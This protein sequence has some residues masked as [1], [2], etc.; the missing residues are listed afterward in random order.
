MLK[1][2]AA[3]AFIFAG[4]SSAWLFLGNTVENRTR[5]SGADLTNRVASVWGGAH[6]QTPPRLL[7]GGTAPTSLPLASTQIRAQLNLEP[8]QKGLLWFN[9][10]TIDFQADYVFTTNNVT[11]LRYEFPLPVARAQYDRALIL[12]DGRE[13]PFES[14]NGVLT[15]R[16]ETKQPTVRISTRYVSKGQEAWQ[17]RFGQATDR[18]KDFDLRLRTNFREVDFADN[19]MAPTSKRPIDGGWELTWNY[20]SLL[21]GFPVKVVMP[22]RLQP[23]PLGAAISYF[24]P[25]SLFFFFFVM[26]MITTVRQVKLHPMNYFFLAAAFFAFHLLFAYLA[27]HLNIHAT[28]LICSLVSCFL[29]VSY[30]RL[31]VN[32]RFAAV[33]AGL[34]QFVFL[35]LFSYAQFFQGYAG[36]TV[37]IGAILALFLV[38]QFTARIDWSAVFDSPTTGTVS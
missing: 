28:F 1:H 25:V 6:V 17:Y 5:E 24:A 4:A 13:A 22:E 29:V 11:D 12:I 30:L 8:R 14:A 32:L 15:A 2:I 9:T 37:T 3:L 33:E 34:A 10:Y 19:T 23:G 20:A 21:S 26:L 31:V 16:I 36:L 7:T 38:M 27:D 35:I 18:V